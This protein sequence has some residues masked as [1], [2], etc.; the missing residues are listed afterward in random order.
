MTVP[1]LIQNYQRQSYVTQLHKIYN[2]V[3]QAALQMM[4]ENN[5]INLSEAGIRSQ[6]DAEKLIEDHFKIINKCGA[7]I[8]PCFPATNTYRKISG[9]SLT[10]WYVPR[11]HYVIASG[12]SIGISYRTNGNVLCELYVDVNGQKGPN[13]VGRDLFPL[14]LYNNGFIDDNNFSADLTAPMTKEQRET[15][16]AVCANNSSSSWHG[17][18]GKILNDNWQMTY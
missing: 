17:C 3:S 18:F 5:A 16:Y 12:A 7:D 10:G 13:I 11:T 4:T 1:S 15:N 9:A 8:T 14:F 6:A 2:E